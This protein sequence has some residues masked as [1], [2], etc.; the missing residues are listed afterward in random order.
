MVIVLD[1]EGLDQHGQLGSILGHQSG[2]QFAH[3]QAAHSHGLSQLDVAAQLGAAIHLKGNLT[4]GTGLDSLNEVLNTVGGRRTISVAVSQS[5][6]DG[7]QVSQRISI[8]SGSLG[9]GSLSLGS[10]GSGGG[11]LFLGAAGGQGEDHGQGHQ[12]CKNSFHDLKHLSFY[13]CYG[14]EFVTSPVNNEVSK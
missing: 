1:Q 10:L 9:L 7:I 6:N 4:I 14:R 5:D 2:V 12:D 3:L 8:S 13:F 11:S